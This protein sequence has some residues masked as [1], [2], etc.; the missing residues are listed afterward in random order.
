MSVSHS[1][2]V[3]RALALLANGRN[4]DPFAVLGPHPDPADGRVLIRAFRPFALSMAVRL[5][6]GAL[7]MMTRRSPNGV[8][9]AFV[10]A[11]VSH[12]RLSATYPGDRVLEFDDPYRYG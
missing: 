10:G 6:D 1:F 8:Y 2:T 4:R 3:D 7:R 9:E 5:P 12:Y 11:D